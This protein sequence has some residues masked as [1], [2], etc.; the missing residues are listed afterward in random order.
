MITIVFLF[1]I[2]EYNYDN[3]L[4]GLLTVKDID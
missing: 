4:N 1:D 2:Y 3:S